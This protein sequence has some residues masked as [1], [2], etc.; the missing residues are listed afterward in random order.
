[1]AKKAKLIPKGLLSSDE[2]VVFESRPSALKYMI[3]GSVVMLI[4]I[5]SL[6]LYAWQYIP[7]APSIPYLSEYLDGEYGEYIEWVLLGIFALALLYFIAKWLRWGSTVYA[8]TDERVIT[9]KGIL[10][11]V[12]DDVPL[13]QITNVDVSQSIG[14]R[15]VGYGTIVFSTTG[16]TGRK[17]SVVWEAVPAPLTVRRKLQEVMD[18]RVKPPQK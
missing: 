8:I 13:T 6:V 10:N 4:G 7:D 16:S 15:M 2:R 5:A 18:V 9:Q 11:K 1:M 12:Y 17:D 3:A 14:K